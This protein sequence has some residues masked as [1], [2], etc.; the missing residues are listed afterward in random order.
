MFWF[1]I[2]PKPC[3]KYFFKTE[4]FQGWAGEKCWLH[5]DTALSHV[6]AHWSFQNWNDYESLCNLRERRP[7]WMKQG[8][9]A[10]IL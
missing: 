2:S 7:N 6:V 8:I 1:G 3:F 5:E 4:T 9:M 10:M